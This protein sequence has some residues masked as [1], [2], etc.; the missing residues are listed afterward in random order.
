MC[1]RESYKGAHGIVVVYDVTDKDSFRA[2]DNWMAE[3]EKFASESAIKIFVGNKC[4]ADEKRKVTF[5]EGK[6][7]AGRYNVKFLETSAKTTKGVHDAFQMLAK[8]IKAKVLP[9]KTTTSIKTPTPNGAKKLT[10]GKGKAVKSGCC[11][12]CLY[13]PYN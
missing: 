6:D 13:Q 4:D 7:V 5:E 9:K 1:I 3:V 10:S 8:E 11:Q 2:I 12:I